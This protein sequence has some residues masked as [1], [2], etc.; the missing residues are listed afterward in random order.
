MPG[1]A[2]RRVCGY[3]LAVVAASAALCAPVAG[4]AMLTVGSPMNAGTPFPETHT[5]TATLANIALGEPGANVTSPV[6]G[7]IVRWRVAT[8]GTGQYSLRVLRP[9][10]SGQYVAVGADGQTVSSAGAQTFSTSLPIRAGDL[11]GVD[12]PTNGVDGIA[13][14][15][16]S[17]SN[18]AL[19]SPSVGS[20]PAT[21]TDQAHDGFEVYLNADVE[22][23]PASDGPPALSGSSVKK[24]EK[25]HE[26]EKAKRK[27]HKRS[28]SAA[29]SKCK[30][31]KK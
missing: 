2:R 29:K 5:G 26:E 9:T 21:P 20:T 13:G 19:W 8:T 6:T 3:S 31:K 15:Q 10:G 27:K 30:K 4:A 17:G 25:K 11:L 18:W 12:I 1:S 28:A 14:I 23:T 16:A 24:C 22:Y 7:S